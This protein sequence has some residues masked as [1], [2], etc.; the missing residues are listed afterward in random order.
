MHGNRWQKPRGTAEPR[1][2]ES[3]C[4]RL[5]RAPVPTGG[6]S[7][8]RRSVCA[9]PRPGRRRATALR[10]RRRALAD[11]GSPPPPQTAPVKVGEDDEEKKKKK[12]E[13]EE[14]EAE[15]EAEKVITMIKM[16]MMI[17]VTIR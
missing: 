10:R 13:E 8:G 15:E 11:P 7:R 4:A 2:Q 6:Q 17:M 12:E 5:T 14:E 16:K 3:T 9:P 1:G